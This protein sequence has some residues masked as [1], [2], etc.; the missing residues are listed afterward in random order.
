[1]GDPKRPQKRFE[2]PNKPWDKDRIQKELVLIGRYGLRNKRE[3]WKLQ[4]QISNYR[5]R[6]RKLLSRI[7]NP[8]EVQNRELLEKLF[9]IGVLPKNAT[10]DDVLGL[11]IENLLERRLQ[12][13]VYN[14]GLASTI[15]HAR[16]LITHNHI[17]LRGEMINVP[18]YLVKRDEEKE[19][20]YAPGSP[21]NNPEHVAR[22]NI[23]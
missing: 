1:M 4:T 17:V 12:T 9:R 3:I 8:D 6:A 14:R 23:Q 19:I 10:L 22:P 16:Q 21:L 18:G 2:R 15:Y 7:E 13:M 20:D 11:T 5:S